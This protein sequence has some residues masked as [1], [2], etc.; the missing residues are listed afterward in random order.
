MAGFCP[1]DWHGTTDEDLRQ[2]SMGEDFWLLGGEALIYPHRR[3]AYV[4]DERERAQKIVTDKAHALAE[5]LGL[6]PYTEETFL[7]LM[8]EVEAKDQPHD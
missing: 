2:M 8:Q 1:D 5:R 7:K 4:V 6:I 3:T